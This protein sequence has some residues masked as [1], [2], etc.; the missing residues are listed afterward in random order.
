MAGKVIS[1]EAII[2]AKDNTGPAFTGV[3]KRLDQLVDASR[4]IDRVAGRI[5]ESARSVDM[6]GRSFNALSGAS[7]RV[8]HI[9]HSFE[10]LHAKVTGAERAVR[11]FSRA[12]R[13]LPRQQPHGGLAGGV[14][15]SA[16]A[17]GAERLG[18]KVVQQYQTFDD[19]VRYQRAVLGI[20]EAEQQPLVK[21]AMKIG[22]ETR[23]TNSDV[24]RAQN[25]LIGRDIR[26]LPVLMQMVGKA[27]DYANAMGSTLEEAAQALEGFLFS[28]GKDVSTPEKAVRQSQH[29]VDMMVQLAK[30]GGMSDEDIRGA[31]KFG[32]APGALAG[33]SDET[34]A[35]MFALMRRSNIRGDE[36]G[37]AL[38]AF[39]A[40]LV[41]PTKKGM[42][43]L[44][45]LG[46]NYFDY[47]KPGPRLNSDSL[48]S[49]MKNKF[50]SS[51]STK[52]AHRAGAVFGNE[53]AMSDAGNF[54]VAMFKAL[55]PLFHRDRHGKMRV[56]DSQKLTK[57]IG[58]YYKLAI[59]GVDAEGLLRAIIAA[60]PTLASA[61]ALFGFRQGGKF[62]LG[63]KGLEEFDTKRNE[64]VETPEGLAHHIAEERLAGFSGAVYNLT[65]SFENLITTI[66][67]VN[68]QA[69][70][71]S[72]NRLADAVNV[73]A[74]LPAPVLRFT[75]ELA[76]AT[77]ALI[78][79]AGAVK[80]GQFVNGVA[81]GSTAA[82]VG[83]GTAAAASR[84]GLR[85]VPF[86]LAVGLAAYEF[87]PDI[88]EDALGHQDHP[89]KGDPWRQRYDAA[90]P[91]DTLD[92]LRQERDER[93]Q[94]R[95]QLHGDGGG[96][97]KVDVQT[98]V[99]V[100]ADVQLNTT[101]FRAEVRSIAED[102][103]RKSV[104][105]TLVNR[106]DGPGSNGT[107]MPDA[108]APYGP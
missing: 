71:G 93:E 62:K 82:G 44:A 97:Q 14:A 75:T 104:G 65:G 103:V 25:T 11:S 13:E 3:A 64:F 8:D 83:L 91:S 22:G 106:N 26:N 87:G 49:Y 66:G 95:Q 37:V 31:Y 74:N 7:S 15:G 70:T 2:S 98:N 43:A 27:T 100:K 57:A 47:T 18:A 94:L 58:D 17:Y 36:A 77:A 101:M 81:G 76:A 53:D 32:G 4:R 39:S 61:N 88:V 73:L 10:A 78:A 69:L 51:L 105:N 92:R 50:G 90:H 20:P 33:L 5:A 72:F 42:D 1:A 24:I 41:S 108:S 46:I 67:R 21:Q 79:F 30:R 86:W 6:F 96:S 68:D 38:R 28:T 29:A 102:V 45:A 9:G 34:V 52:M 107:S 54:K 59:S 85:A 35:A 23:F 84:F 56:G 80:I 99:N 40:N 19:L 55:A 63:T 48:G 60:D 89:T 16:I 12:Q